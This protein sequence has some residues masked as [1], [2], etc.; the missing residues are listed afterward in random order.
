MEIARSQ[1][2]WNM[3]LAG[4]SILLH[5]NTSVLGSVLYTPLQDVQIRLNTAKNIQ[6]D[7]SKLD[8]W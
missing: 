4:K 6:N 2:N 8:M 7:I 5:C 3:M 1:Y